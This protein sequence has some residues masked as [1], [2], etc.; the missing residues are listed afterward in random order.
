MSKAVIYIR[1]ST[2]EQVSNHSLATQ[3]RFCSEYCASNELEVARV[4]E[5]AGESAK[6]ADRP[7]LI[8]MLEYCRTEAVR[9]GITTAVV[10]EVSRLA[11]NVADHA[12]IRLKLRDAGVVVRTVQTP[13]DETPEGALME[14]MMASF[15]QFDND[16]RAARTRRGM[17][18]ALRSGRWNWG[19]PIGYRRPQDPDVSSSLEP[20]PVTA[21]L[22][23]ELFEYVA[24]GGR[25]KADA[26]RFATTIG[27]ASEDGT[28][29]RAE[30]LNKMLANRLYYGWMVSLSLDFE[31][32]GDFEPLIT[33]AVFQRAQA[34]AP[35]N[36]SPTLNYRIDNPDFPLRR[37]VRCQC[38]GGPLTGSWSS[39]RKQKYAYYR[40]ARSACRVSFRRD[41][42]EQ[43]FIEFLGGQSIEGGRFDLFAAVIEDSLQ[44]R[45]AA[46]HS[47]L[48]ALEQQRKKIARKREQLVEAFVYNKAIDQATYDQQSKRISDA[49]QAVVEQIAT[50][51]GPEIEIDACLAFGRHLLTN[52]PECWNQLDEAQ[53][54]R[55]AAAMYPAGLKILGDKIGTA[56]IPWYKAGL[57]VSGDDES[58]VVPPSGIEPLL[59]G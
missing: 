19:A 13:I 4:F 50:Q 32:R 7:Q 15:A 2:Q 33:E 26:L 10:L 48:T 16:T 23:R 12:V 56:Q 1:V 25:T 20:D 9:E 54:P 41:E 8:E 27:L 22:V 21:P 38:C 5:D 42:L 55:F 36:H 35:G 43:M 3:R 6:T 46:G 45:G 28:P 11:R 59:P 17:L 44:E 47:T 53:R 39:G 24:Q 40:C 49:E 34:A 52:L 58:P 37:T 57:G 14:N 51:S 30:R 29:L 18:E 31:G